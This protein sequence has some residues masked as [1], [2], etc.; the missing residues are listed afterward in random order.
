MKVYYTIVNYALLLREM[1]VELH[2]VYL[3]SF[4]EKVNLSA[5]YQ[6]ELA[7]KILI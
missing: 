7:S 2:D 3:N 1:R 6:D 5:L 4:I